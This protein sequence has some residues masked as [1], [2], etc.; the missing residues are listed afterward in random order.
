VTNRS[1][2]DTYVF[3]WNRKVAVVAPGQ[4]KFVLFEALVDKLG[5]PRSMERESQRY[6]DG[7]GNQGVVMSREFEMDRLFTRYAVLGSHINDTKDKDGSI[8][9]GLLFK[10]PHVE[11]ETLNGERVVFPAFRPDMLPF[12]IANVNEHRVRSDTISALDKL[13]SENAEMREALNTLNERLTTEIRKREGY[14]D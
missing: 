1:G 3:E 12:P 10:T 14:E 7:N 4:A 6:N 8:I 9:P 2:T 5:D 13:E 11:V